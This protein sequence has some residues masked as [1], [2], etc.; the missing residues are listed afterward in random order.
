MV[1]ECT[2]VSYDTKVVRERNHPAIS[3]TEPDRHVAPHLGQVRQAHKP[4]DKP[5]RGTFSLTDKRT[6]DL[7]THVQW[8]TMASRII[9]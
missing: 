3:P 1:E 7:R 8:I 9:G 2:S 6:V 4:P 5:R